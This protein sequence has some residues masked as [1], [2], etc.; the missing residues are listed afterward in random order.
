[1]RD[2][3]TL[4]QVHCPSGEDLQRF[5]AGDLAPAEV[6]K[7]VRHL[8]TGCPACVRET[9]GLWDLGN[10]DELE[11]PVPAGRTLRIQE[12]VSWR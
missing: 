4:L 1:M 6:R 8:L 2:S 5:M 7:V 9:H 10:L 11:E 3:Q 12:V